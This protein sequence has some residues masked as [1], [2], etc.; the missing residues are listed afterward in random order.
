M[1]ERLKRKNG[2]DYIS[3]VK[4]YIDEDKGVIEATSGRIVKRQTRIKAIDIIDVKV[5]DTMGSNRITL[6]TKHKSLEIEDIKDYQDTL[7]K[8]YNMMDKADN[9]TS[10][11]KLK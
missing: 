2:M 4:Y 3:S 11:I 8:I 5:F 7:D 10:H 9:N 6:I 1:R